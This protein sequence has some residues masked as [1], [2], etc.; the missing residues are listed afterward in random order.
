MADGKREDKRR[1][2]TATDESEVELIAAIQGARRRGNR[3]GALHELLT[4]LYAD[5]HVLAGLKRGRHAIGLD[6]DAGERVGVVDACRE[7]GVVGGVVGKDAE[8]GGD[9]CR[10]CHGASSRLARR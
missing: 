1:K 6:P 4:D 3:V 9:R 5:R 8:R 10:L 7:G 2:R